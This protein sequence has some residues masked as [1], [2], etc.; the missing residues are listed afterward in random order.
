M[1]ALFY[2]INLINSIVFI[3]PIQLTR[4]DFHLNILLF[5]KNSS[6][7]NLKLVYLLEPVLN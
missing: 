4:T 7:I 6:K 5:E 3:K 1:N 2:K